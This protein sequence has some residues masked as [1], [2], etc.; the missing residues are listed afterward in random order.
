MLECDFIAQQLIKVTSLYKYSIIMCIHLPNKLA[1][2]LL[3][4][5]F[6]QIKVFKTRLTANNCYMQRT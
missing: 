2:I 6:L 3:S 5:S 1:K 4:V